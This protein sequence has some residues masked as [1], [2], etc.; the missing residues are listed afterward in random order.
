MAKASVA[1]RLAIIQLLN[2]QP[3][4]AYQALRESKLADLPADLRRSRSLIEARALSDLSRTDLALEML[5]PERG[6]EVERLRADI[7]W[8]SRRWREAGE[9]FERILGDTW[10]STDPLDERSRADVLRAA[11]AYGLGDEA[12]SLE[13]L[14]AKFS[15]KMADSADAR[16]FTTLTSSTG[17][18]ASEYRELAKTVASADTLGEFLSEYRKRY[19]DLPV[20]P[21]KKPKPQPQAETPPKDE[22]KPAAE[23]GKAEKPGAEKPGAEKPAAEAATG[24]AGEGASKPEAD[25]GGAPAEKPAAAAEQKPA[26]GHG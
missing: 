3:A 1:T 21:P 19:P 9:Q 16:A 7:L 5:A 12:L 6:A 2:H 8:Q 11:I 17:A 24:K 4:K 20:L 23:K 14:R 15:P 22:A 25:K 18:R 13:R 10:Q 26:G